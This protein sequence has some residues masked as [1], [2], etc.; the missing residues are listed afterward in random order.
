MKIVFALGAL[1]LLSACSPSAQ[2]LTL[3]VAAVNAGNTA[4]AIIAGIISP[5]LAGP[6]SAAA[7]ALNASNCVAVKA[8]GGSC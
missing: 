1:A 4:G 8:A 5:A 3:G 2:Q 6:A 7:A